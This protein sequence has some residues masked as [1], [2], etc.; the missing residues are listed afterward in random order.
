MHQEVLLAYFS[1]PGIQ[2]HSSTST[3]YPLSTPQLRHVLQAPLKAALGWLS[4]LAG[5]AV[6]EVVRGE[7]YNYRS[8]LR[9]F[10]LYCS[11]KYS[12]DTVAIYTAVTSETVAAI[13]AVKSWGILATLAVLWWSLALVLP[14]LCIGQV[15]S[16]H[17]PDGQLL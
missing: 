4:V 16:L 17:W 5:G 9:L 11:C 2:V 10:C 12:P 8:L 6:W 1:N 15:W 13:S 7:L 14:P 3:L